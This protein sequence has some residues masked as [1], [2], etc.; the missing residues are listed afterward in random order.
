MSA[1]QEQKSNKYDLEDD[2]HLRAF[3]Y[4]YNGIKNGVKCTKEKETQIKKNIAFLKKYKK[5]EEFDDIQ[6]AIRESAYY[7]I[8]EMITEYPHLVEN[9]NSFNIETMFEDW[10]KFDLDMAVYVINILGKDIQDELDDKIDF[11]AFD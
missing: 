2:R 8:A 6:Y 5:H 4:R 1:T 9:A 7:I 11:D 3:I 10:F